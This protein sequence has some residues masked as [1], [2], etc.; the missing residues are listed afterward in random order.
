MYLERSFF[1]SP[2][3]N[4]GGNGWENE[5]QVLRLASKLIV[6][7]RFGRN[8]FGCFAQDDIF[9]YMLKVAVVPA[10]GALE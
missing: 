2:F 10:F 8:E 7:P 9:A 6:A 4:D 1:L 3:P 5:M